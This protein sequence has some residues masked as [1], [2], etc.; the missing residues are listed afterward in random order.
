MTI[1][2]LTLIRCRYPFKRIS[3]VLSII[4]ILVGFRAQGQTT[5]ITGPQNITVDNFHCYSISGF[6]SSQGNVVNVH[7]LTCTSS[8][9]TCSGGCV[10]ISKG[11]TVC[12]VKI[13]IKFD[14]QPYNT[15]DP[16]LIY[17][18]ND[19]RNINILPWIDIPTFIY[20]GENTNI[21]LHDNCGFAG[22]T[23]NWDVSPASI[24]P[25]CGISNNNYATVYINP[26]D[27]PATITANCTISNCSPV[28]S[29]ALNPQFAQIKL[30]KP[31]LLAGPNTIGC[32]SPPP[33]NG[34]QY[35]V[36]TI[37]GATS[38]QWTVPDFLTIISGQSTNQITVKETA[39]GSGYITVKALSSNPYVYSDILSIPVQVCCLSSID[40]ANPVNAPNTEDKE[41]AFNIN[42]SNIIYAGA[43]A[44]YHAELYVHL[45]PNFSAQ[46]NSD[47]HA[48]PLGCTGTFYRPS[49]PESQGEINFPSTIENPNSENS[50]N[51]YSESNNYKI[52]NDVKVFPNPNSGVFKIKLDPLVDLPEKIIIQN[53]LEKE[54]I[55]LD[56]PSDYF[57]TIN[58]KDNPIG[59]YLVKI[60]YTNKTIIR[61][62]I[63]N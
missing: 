7:P 37:Q 11:V 20:P 36:Y 19:E 42:A 1:L 52:A 41:A 39:L 35:Q 10:K 44:R 46:Y 61:K 22:C 4:S 33:S 62:A 31:V 49:Q 34:F 17:T 59:I 26:N 27:L 2:E 16:T 29:E 12:S 24:C 45:S 48:Y 50:N 6:P 15:I 9:A 21:T 56:K 28:S 53:I 5:Y 38:Y 58:L 8:F 14:V 60:V 57:V 3:S 18:V 47:F 30:K 54:V 55:S 63:K 13:Q 23:Y 25:G 32:G 43:K 40:L 51:N